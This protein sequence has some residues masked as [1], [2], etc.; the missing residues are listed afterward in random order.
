ML[1]DLDL[2]PIR[3]QLDQNFCFGD[4]NS[5][6]KK[7]KTKSTPKKPYSSKKVKVGNVSRNICYRRIK[8]NDAFNV[9]FITDCFSFYYKVF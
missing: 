4:N 9:S 8:E 6:K 1:K 7:R 3:S 2:G 5:L